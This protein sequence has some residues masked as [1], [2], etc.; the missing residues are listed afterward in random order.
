MSVEIAAQLTLVYI[1][2]S[3]TR[4][5]ISVTFLAL[6]GG[7]GADALD[8]S[9]PDSKVARN[10][11]ESKGEG[12]CSVSASGI[13]FPILFSLNPRKTASSLQ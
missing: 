7:L 2:F 1:T 5:F 8:P 6:L 12:Y 3:M 11:L 13:I 9:R 4:S 10:V